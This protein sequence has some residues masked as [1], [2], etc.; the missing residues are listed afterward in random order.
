MSFSNLNTFIE[1]TG[2]G[3]T[4]TFPINFFI[5]ENS[6]NITAEVF[7]VT[8]PLNPVQEFPSYSIDHTNYPASE[9]VFVAPPAIGRLVRL[10]RTTAL[11]QT[12]DFEKGAFPA[13]AVEETFDKMVMMLQ[14]VNY[15]LS[16]KLDIDD[17]VDPTDVQNQLDAHTLDITTNTSGIATNTS[18]IG[19]NASNIATNS[20]GITA[21]Q[22]AVSGIIP[23]T[24][25]IISVAGVHN[26]SDAEVVVVKS[27]NVTI[28][29]P[30][31]TAGRKVTVKMDGVRSNLIVSSS[32]GIDGFGTTYTLSS[33][34]ESIAFIA[35][36]T[37]WY[38]I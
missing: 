17:Y 29:L 24:L 26:A 25:A 11:I 32:A 13:E 33:N 27:D 12:S 9:A 10:R 34:Y 4:D 36:G 2:D 21:L 18:S 5:L 35:D 28:A 8:D 6:A 31:E 15:G 14:E 20:S 37:Q 38:I 22:L 19:T 23:A 30:T 1:Y 3:V 16:L 7:D